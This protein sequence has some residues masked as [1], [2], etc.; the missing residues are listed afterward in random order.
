MRRLMIVCLLLVLAVSG[1]AKGQGPQDV[2][3]GDQTKDQTK[4]QTF[5]RTQDQLKLNDGSCQDEVVD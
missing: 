2:S 1:Y 3:K 5:D 4:D